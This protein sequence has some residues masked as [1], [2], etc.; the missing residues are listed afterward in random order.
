M[1][2][3]GSGSHV[4]RVVPDTERT[5]EDTL[6][7]LAPRV[8]AWLCRDLGQND[9]DDALQDSLTEIAKALPKFRGDSQLDTYVYRIAMRVALRYHKARKRRRERIEIAPPPADQIDPE[10][11]AMSREALRG[12]YRGLDKL[13]IKRRRAFVLCCIEGL[14]AP[15]AAAR[16]GVRPDAM[17]SRLRHARADLATILSRDVYLRELLER[18]Q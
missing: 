7:E 2:P 1:S 12:L 6:T 9:V 13:A 18:C 14:S 3:P 5:L 10:S 8:K 15:E 11:R 16:E 17:R 4:L